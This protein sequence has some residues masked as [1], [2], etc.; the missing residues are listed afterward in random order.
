[1]VRL[2]CEISVVFMLVLS[3]GYAASLHDLPKGDLNESLDN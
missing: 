2:L 3:A 1:M